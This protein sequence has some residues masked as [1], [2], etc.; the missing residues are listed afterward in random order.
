[1]SL[2]LQAGEQ[3]LAPDWADVAG[4][5]VDGAVYKWGSRCSVED[6]LQDTKNRKLARGSLW[7]RP[8]APLVRVR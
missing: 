3:R 6:V 2:A 5:V 7:H 8:T 4:R 1:M